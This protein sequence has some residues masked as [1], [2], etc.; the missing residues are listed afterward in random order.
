M[1]VPTDMHGL[2]VGVAAL[3]VK[4]DALNDRLTTAIDR[5]EERT[6]ANDRIVGYQIERAVALGLEPVARKLETLEDAQK[7]AQTAVRTA[8]RIV[9][10]VG[11][12]LTS[13]WGVLEILA[14]FLK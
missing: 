4:V 7:E 10:L 3:E 13:L 8:G 5:V 6:V 14:R 9:M 12:G 11:G 2:A 1:P